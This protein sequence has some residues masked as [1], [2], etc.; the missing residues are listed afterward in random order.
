MMASQWEVEGWGCFRVSEG[1]DPGSIDLH[2]DLDYLKPRPGTL[3]ALVLYQQIGIASGEAV[4]QKVEQGFS[5]AA[6]AGS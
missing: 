2:Q 5:S 3:P 6:S 4:E 1:M